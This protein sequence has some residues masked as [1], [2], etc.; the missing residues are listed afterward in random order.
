MPVFFAPNEDYFVLSDSIVNEKR[1]QKNRM[2][3]QRT[4][5][6]ENVVVGYI[7]KVPFQLFI[8]LLCKILLF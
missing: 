3:M 5:P 7:P 4:E 6:N 8:F 2:I 1:K